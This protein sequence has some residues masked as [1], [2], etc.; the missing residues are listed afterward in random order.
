MQ[1]TA[2]SKEALTES[3]GISKK[4][5][6]VYSVAGLLAISLG[7]G[8]GLGAASLLKGGV[9]VDYADID[10]D[11]L[12]D[13][14][15]ALMA[16]YEKTD[17]AD[18]LSTFQPYEMANIANSLFME[19]ENY[20]SVAVGSSKASIVTQGIYGLHMRSGDT[21][22][23][24]S[25]SNG[26]VNLYDRMWEEGDT[27]TIRWGSTSDYAS[28]TPE[29][30]SNEDYVTKMGRKVSDFSSY[31]V[32][33]KTTLIDTSN[34]GLS[35]TSAE[36]T[37]DGGYKVEL[38]LDTVKSVVN[39]VTQM[40]TISNLASKPSFVYCHLT[41]YLD[42]QL[43]PISSTSY[44]RYYAKTSSGIGSYCEG[45]LTSKYQ[46]GG[47]ASIPST[48]STD[49]YYNNFDSFITGEINK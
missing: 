35:V 32:S 6:V 16:K 10:G 21:Y 49:D 28:M 27:T 36:K 25:I 13:D 18:Y 30:M 45:S 38:E 23:E 17:E 14:L 22:F 20:C 29:S 12:T 44:E 42:A 3:V 5:I 24:E 39:Y 47:E 43:R 9:N 1:D 33:S 37:E 8:A 40:Q 41:Y 7:I 34:S 46:W 15:D 2:F 19:Q 11:S 26:M 4:T 31:I 48:E